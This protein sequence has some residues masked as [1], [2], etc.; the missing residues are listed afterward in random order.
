MSNPSN[1][2]LFSASLESIE[3]G[4]RVEKFERFK[5]E[6][7]REYIA[8]LDNAQEWI[9]AELPIVTDYIDA[10]AIKDELKQTKISSR[11]KHLLSA[12]LFEKSLRE[13][14]D[15]NNATTAAIM[16]IHM[17]NNMWQAKVELHGS[18][19][20]ATT[21]TAIE[22]YNDTREKILTTLI[23]K[24]EK[25]KQD[26]QIQSNIKPAGQSNPLAQKTDKQVPTATHNQT[27]RP[28]KAINKPAL[29]T[30][31]KSDLWTEESEKARQKKHSSTAKNKKSK[32]KANG[33]FAKVKTKIPLKRNKR[34][35]TRNHID[36]PKNITSMSPEDSLLDDPNR[37][38]II[39]S[40]GF[41]DS[42][43]D[44][45]IK[46][47]AETIKDPNASGVTVHKVLKNPN[48]SGV[49][50]HRSLKD[51]D[52]DKQEPGSNT[53]IMKLASSTGKRSKGKTSVPEQC[54]DAINMLTQQFPG[55]DMVAIRHM[56]AEKVGVSPQYIENLN[57]LPDKSA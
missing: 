53:I 6:F 41:A 19:P 49:T 29:P 39:V 10:P 4:K 33:M 13:A 8:T 43:D 48:E 7:Q 36:E 22:T 56:A 14:I 11:R 12:L 1:H 40:P 42:I 55:Y 44:S 37:S 38:A 3:T 24:G 50:V 25:L 47:R 2:D 46:A 57:I 23:E 26:S 21:N 9:K 20:V 17:F 30:Q 54:Q 31:R 51:R 45:I 16:A 52:H 32:K 15:S 5:N 27:A 18:A 28:K 35:K 34:T